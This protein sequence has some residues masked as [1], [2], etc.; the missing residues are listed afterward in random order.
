MLD[1]KELEGTPQFEGLNSEE[2]K[3]LSH[4]V[5][6]GYYKKGEAI[7]KENQPD[8]SLYIIKKGE[9]KLEKSAT[10]A[11]KHIGNLLGTGICLGSLS[12][13]ADVTYPT[14]VRA[15]SDCE[16]LVVDK[17]GFKQLTERNPGLGLKIMEGVTAYLCHLS[18]KLDERYIDI[19]DY[20]IDGELYGSRHRPPVE[21]VV[22]A[23][24]KPLTKV[25]ARELT[26]IS[27]FADFA[28]DEREEIARIMNGCEYKEG[29]HIFVE[30]TSG[31]ELY[32]IQAGMVKISKKTQEGKTTTLSILKE[33][34]F[35][36]VLS[37]L[38]QTAHTATA[39]V[40]K[41]SRILIMEK[42]AFEELARQ[43][44]RC[45]LNLMNHIYQEVYNL[46]N[47]IEHDLNFTSNYVWEAG[48]FYL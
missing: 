29:E 36:G 15:L 22:Q 31:G 18:R 5:A 48:P 4:I 30:H 41:D 47:K 8:D 28:A 44:P 42:Q 20:M 6:K 26:G 35:F 7:V 23:P 16:L 43:D 19:V 37:L 13:S 38:E 10:Q 45:G 27:L 21:E 32:I 25:S 1:V 9:V 33:G 40:V 2:F 46:L 12:P 39:E 34:K 3:Q 24:A 11:G 17:A 14:T